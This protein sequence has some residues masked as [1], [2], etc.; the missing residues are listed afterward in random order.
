[1]FVIGPNGR[2]DNKEAII[3]ADLSPWPNEVPYNPT[4]VQYGTGYN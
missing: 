2:D 4:S 1:M 3:V